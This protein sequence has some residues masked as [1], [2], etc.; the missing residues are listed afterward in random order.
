MPRRLF[1]ILLL[2][3]GAIIL[4]FTFIS[5]GMRWSAPHRESIAAAGFKPGTP[6]LA[7]ATYS[8]TLVVPRLKNESTDWIESFFGTEDHMRLRV[9]VADDEEAEFH[10]PASE[11]GQDF[12]RA[13]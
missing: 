7:G 10:P 11:F 12:Q 1:H 2:G 13:Y 9:Y 6:K 3:I 8:R 5:D 4:W